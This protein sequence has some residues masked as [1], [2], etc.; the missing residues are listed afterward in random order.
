LSFRRFS[1]RPQFAVDLG[2]ANTVVYRRGHGIVLFE[3]SIVAI[4]ERSGS[5]Y[6][7]GRRHG[8]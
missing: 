8:G 3:P 7:S 2:T 1:G 6:G 4:D 5:V